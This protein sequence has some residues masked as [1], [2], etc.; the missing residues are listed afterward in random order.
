MI[1][2][3]A[4]WIWNLAKQHFPGA[5]RIVDLFHARQHLWNL[6]RLLYPNHTKFSNAWIGLH[7]KRWLDKGKIANSSPP[8]IRFKPRTP[9]W[10]KRSAPKPTTLPP[11]RLA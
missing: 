6:A 4:E 11:R 2:D 3:G 9:I 5:I 1:G 8:F 10:P 7:Q